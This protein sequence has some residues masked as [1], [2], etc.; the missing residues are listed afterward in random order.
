[1]LFLATPTYDGSRQNSVS[2]TA[3]HLAAKDFGIPV[4]QR[5]TSESL[6]AANVNASWCQMLN[7]RSEITHYLLLHADVA[8][9]DYAWVIQMLQEMERYG[10]DVLSVVIPIKSKEGLT[11]TALDTSH[12]APRRYTMKEIFHQPETWTNG[13]LLV[14]TGCMLVDARKPWV[15]EVCFTINDRI[16]KRDGVFSHLVEG[17]DW[18]FSRQCHSL[19]AEVFVTRKVAIEH[20]DGKTVYT[21]TEPWG[22][23][24]FDTMNMEESVYD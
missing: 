5:D 23:L 24:E 4:V 21:N 6:L 8:P 10:A 16:V 9:V 18:N 15:E 22:T 17:E 13:K 20:Y 14:N 7:M 19:G 12:W 1:M 3:A 11:S 2:I